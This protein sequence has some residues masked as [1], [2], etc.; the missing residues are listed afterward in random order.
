MIW[1]RSHILMIDSVL[2]L[3]TDMVVLAGL[4]GV[5][6]SA[7]IQKSAMWMKF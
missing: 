7:A 3:L 6:V 2:F 1:H 5:S 4:Y